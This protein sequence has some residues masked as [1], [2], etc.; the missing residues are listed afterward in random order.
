MSALS[1]VG[2]LVKMRAIELRKAERVAREVRGSP[3]QK[4]ADAGVVAAVDEFHEFR[5]RAV[6]ASSGEIANCLIAPGTI[7]GM[8]HDGKQFDVGV[9]EIFDVGNELIAEF[10]VSEPAI[11]ILGN[12]TP[13]AEMDFVNRHGRFEPIF[14][15]AAVDPLV[16]GPLVGVEVDDDRAGVGTQLRAEGVRIRFEGEHRALR[17]NDFV[18]VDG[19]FAE[20][21]NEEFPDSRRAASA[22]G[23]DAAIP[24]VEVADEADAA[25]AR[26]P[27]GEMNA[28][29]PFERFEV[30][31]EFFVGVVVAAFSH[32]MEIKLA[33]KIGERVG[34]K[35]FDGFTVAGTKANAIGA[36][37]WRALLRI[38]KR[39]FKE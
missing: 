37:S 20:F 27:N 30:R 25:R 16:V 35:S 28:A 39:G 15:G 29:D 14:L 6:A 10:A 4:N 7:E 12:A 38:R 21:G 32:E 17:A 13:R 18:L 11:V 8:F 34:V 9:A 31:A 36:G 22:H 26:G 1:R 23:I 3:V 19:A 33:E 5:G 2:V 24:V